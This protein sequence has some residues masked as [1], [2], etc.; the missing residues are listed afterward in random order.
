MYKHPR[1]LPSVPKQDPR[2]LPS[3]PKQDSS[4]GEKCDFGWTYFEHTSHCYLVTG[5]AKT[6][7]A[8]QE[9]CKTKGA[10]LVTITSPRE[11]QDVLKLIKLGERSK[12]W[13]GMKAAL[14]WYDSS[15]SEYSNWASGEPD[16]QATKPC[17]WMYGDE[18]PQGLWVADHCE[19]LSEIATV[20]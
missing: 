4:S 14:S 15:E 19:L 20:C 16:G 1:I 2:I 10:N 12:A 6:W 13:I 18:K 8:A 17:V 5:H 11:N 9:D 7:K 3:V